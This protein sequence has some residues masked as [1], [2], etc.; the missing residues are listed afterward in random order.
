PHETPNRAAPITTIMKAIW[1]RRA[2][3][4]LAVMPLASKLPAARC[5][6]PLR[7]TAPHH[8]YYEA[9]LVPPRYE[10]ARGH[11]VGVKAPGGSVLRTDTTGNVV[12]LVAG[13][14]QNPYD[15]AFTREGE[16]LTADSDMEWDSGLS[17][18]RPTRVN[19]LIA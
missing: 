6:A 18:Y 8:H 4:M 3:K 19:H 1:S 2:M 17:W 5:C 15:I 16:L 12:E 7:P 14:L 9:D 13:G 10:D 11:A